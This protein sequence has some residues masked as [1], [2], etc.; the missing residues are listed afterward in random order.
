MSES[1]QIRKHFKDIVSDLPRWRLGMVGAVC[2]AEK[3]LLLFISLE[4]LAE[5]DILKKNI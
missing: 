5:G 4:L 3:S 2:L 1:V